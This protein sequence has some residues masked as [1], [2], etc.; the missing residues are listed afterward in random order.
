M[1]KAY[2]NKICVYCGQNPSVTD[3]HIFARGFCLE[4]H[5]ANLPKVPACGKCNGD[6]SQLEHYLT[7]VLPFGGQHR[8]SAETLKTLVPPRLKKNA[9]LDRELKV[10]YSGDKIPL[11]DRKI[12]P[13]FEF[14]AKGLLSHHWGIILTPSDCVAAIVVR[15]E[16]HG[17]LEHLFTKLAPRNRVVEN[18]ADGALVYEGVQAKDHAQLTL[19]RFLVYGGLQFGESPLDSGAKHC[20][21]FAVTGPRTLLANFWAGVFKEQLPAA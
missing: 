20:V 10:G 9:K 15:S 18:I 19:W 6:K 3:D 2:K 12:E 13:L 11:R 1:R 4:R 14:I 21:I 16:G 8:A 7:A 17:L 5:R